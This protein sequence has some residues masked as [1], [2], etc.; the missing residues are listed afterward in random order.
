MKK[1]LVY[2]AIVAA[3]AIVAGAFVSFGPPQLLAK[4]ETPEFCGS[5]HVMSIEYE[6]WLRSVHRSVKCIDCH[7][8]NDG[9]VEHYVWKGIDG[10]KDVVY[11]YGGLVSE[12][13]HASARAKR[14]VKANCIRCH[15]ELVSRINVRDRNC[16]DCHRRVTHRGAG[17]ILGRSENTSVEDGRKR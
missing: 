8:P 5:C 1:H 16:W 15:G 10:M 4:S 7:L 2:L 17:A 11:F 14:V 6:T 3:I 13:I 9:L 12:E